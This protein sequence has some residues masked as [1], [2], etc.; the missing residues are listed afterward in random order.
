MWLSQVAYGV[1]DAIHCAVS[2]F[3]I[4][5]RADFRPVWVVKGGVGS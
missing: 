1:V 5:D 4:G 3:L 2:A